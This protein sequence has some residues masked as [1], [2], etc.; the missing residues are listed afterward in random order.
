MDIT[1]VSINSGKI[2][3][4]PSMDNIPGAQ[5]EEANLPKSLQHSQQFAHLRQDNR[6]ADLNSAFSPTNSIQHALQRKF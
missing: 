1:T 2:A 4:V 6:S 3:Q 5:P